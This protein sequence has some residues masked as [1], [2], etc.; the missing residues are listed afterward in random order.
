MRNGV[1][2]KTEMYIKPNFPYQ[3]LQIAKESG[4]VGDGILFFYR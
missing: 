1:K 2:N 4:K 3:C